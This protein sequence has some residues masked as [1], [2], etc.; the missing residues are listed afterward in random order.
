MVAQPQLR[1]LRRAALLG[2]PEVLS[3]PSAPQ[4]I[5]PTLRTGVSASLRARLAFVLEKGGQ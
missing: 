2:I 1:L 4:Y 3:D 5:P